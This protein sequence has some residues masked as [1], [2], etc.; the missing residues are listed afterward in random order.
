M[1]GLDRKNILI[2]G[3]GGF[4]GSHLAESLV[5]DNN[6]IAVDNFITSQIENIQ[7]LLEH[8]NFEFIK[9]DIINPIDLNKFPELKQFKVKALGV[10]EIYHLACPTS[11]KHFN[12]YPVE[13][14]LA[15]SYGTKN[16][17]DLARGYG[18]KMLF[19]STAAVY[20]YYRENA[21]IR[22]DYWGEV[23]P[24]GPRSS[25]DEGKRF[26]ESLVMNYRHVYNIDAKIA[27]VFKTYGP[28]M[29]LDDGRLIPDFIDSALNGR[30]LHIYGDEYLT[31]TFCYVSDLVEGLI[32]LMHS[33]EPGPVNFG[34]DHAYRVADVARRITDLTQSKSE[35][36]FNEPLPYPSEHGVPNI[37]RA[38]EILGWFPL[39]SL[40]DGIRKTVEFMKA[41]YRLYG[42]NFKTRN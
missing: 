18:A 41:H 7:F 4:I 35:I 2:T 15:N 21:P 40:D 1:S 16:V 17:L 25:Y 36:L 31:A 39:I 27:R 13:T 3:G 32:R 8:P 38:K 37:N 22:E 9:H 12:K 29:R 11:P 6:V 10:Q 30:P 34:S 33:D 26:S 5:E 42:I 23:N 20:G 14:I 19:T 28:R 24:V